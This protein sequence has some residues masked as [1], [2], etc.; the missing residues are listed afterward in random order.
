MNGAA[1]FAFANRS[2]LTHRLRQTLA[3]EM[4]VET[5]LLY[6]VSHNIAKVEE[7]QFTAKS[8]LVWFIEK[9]QL[10]QCRG[11][12]F[13]FQETWVLDLGSLKDG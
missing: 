3:A 12:Q 4:D 8:A 5:R 1:N 7:H 11:N 6:D 2:A 10:E 13:S 9:V